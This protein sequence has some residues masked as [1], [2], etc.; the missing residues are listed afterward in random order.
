MPRR[1]YLRFISGTTEKIALQSIEGKLVEG[2]YGP[3]WLFDLTDGRG[4]YLDEPVVQ[5]IRNAHIQPGQT[6]WLLKHKATGNGKHRR[7]VWDLYLEDPTRTEGE[8]S[9]HRD[10][11]MSM[12]KAAAPAVVPKPTPPEL[13]AVPVAEIPRKQPAWAT[14][15]D[16][17]SL[18]ELEQL[19]TVRRNTVQTDQEER[20]VSVLIGEIEATMAH[21]RGKQIDGSSVP[22]S[23]GEPDAGG[24]Q[25]AGGCK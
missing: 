4:M 25:S 5:K 19:S 11:R 23:T 9:L 3:Q 12:P 10:L 17:F 16:A 2:M 15:W 13:P 14:R 21:R 24:P 8:S 22:Q 18:D 6:F 1:E 7:N 20:I